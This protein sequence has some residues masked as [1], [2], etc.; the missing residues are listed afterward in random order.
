M[1]GAMW[2]ASRIV[3]RI[4]TRTTDGVQ[5]KDR[6]MSQVVETPTTISSAKDGLNDAGTLRSVLSNRQAMLGIADSASEILAA[7]KEH[8]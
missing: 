8:R 2:L 6:K 3:S 1:R 4:A 7:E 5:T